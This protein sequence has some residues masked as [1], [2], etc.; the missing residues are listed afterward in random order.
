MTHRVKQMLIG[1]GF[2]FGLQAGIS[3]LATLLFSNQLKT[4][5]ILFVL[6][7]GLTLGAFLV[8]GF[9]LGVLSDRLRLGDAALVTVATL[10]LSGL[11]LSSSAEGNNFYLRGNW[12]NDASGHFSIPAQSFVCMALALVASSVGCYAGWRVGIPQEGQFDRVA[13]LLGL[14]GAIV[15]PFLLFS[16][17]GDSTT[18]SSQQG[19]PWYFLAIVILVV[20]VIMGIGFLMF[21]RDSH[22]AEEISIHPPKNE[23]YLAEPK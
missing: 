20:L 8:G 5:G 2:T 18:N 14:L 19:L 11:V 21:T 13:L 16:I 10:L 17:G 4:P 22:H 3:F 23:N 9:V 12:L 6:F 7:F 15:G 1:L